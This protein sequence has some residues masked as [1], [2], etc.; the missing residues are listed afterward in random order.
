[1][2]SFEEGKPGQWPIDP[3]SEVGRVRLLIGDSVAEEFDPAE[4]GMGNF[5]LLSDAEICAYLEM[6]DNFNRI[7][8]IIY[9]QLA[10]MAAKESKAVKDYD[11]QV[12]LTKRATDLRETAKMWFSRADAE[13]D[14]L[15]DEAFEIVPTGTGTGPFVP[16]ATIAQWGRQ[17]TLGRWR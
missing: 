5:E 17:Y 8:G 13:D 6:D 4:Y 1:M 3:K 14:L 9:L 16:E 12:D 10:G 2:V 15:D 11:L 7:I